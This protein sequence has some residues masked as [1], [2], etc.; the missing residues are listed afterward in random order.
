MISNKTF[1]GKL[2]RLPLRLIPSNAIIPIVRG[3]LRGYKWQIQS[4]SNGYWLGTYEY[5]KQELFA[6]YVKPSNVILDVG[7]NVGYYTLL[8]S[9]LTG[10]KGIVYSFELGIENIAYLNKHLILNKIKNVE[11][12][13]YAVSDKNGVTTFSGKRSK[14]KIDE[15]GSTVVKT[16]TLDSFCESRKI[17]SIDIIKMDIE[18]AEYNALLGAKY[19]LTEFN[20]ILFLATHGR[21]VHDNC[22]AFLSSLEYQF[23]VLD[24][25][26]RSYT[27]EIIAWKE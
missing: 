4:G 14:G 27:N 11:V 13:A 2:L 23:K 19:I 15:K 9:V 1:L 5:D 10:E 3:A 24:E 16:I 18:G 6:Q 8:A 20:P 21:R 25:Q 17:S 7:A 22:V 26:R 12:I